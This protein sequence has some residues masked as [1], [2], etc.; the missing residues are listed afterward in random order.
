MT[1][2]LRRCLPEEGCGFLVGRGETA[3]RFV[4]APNSLGSRMAWAVRPGFLFDLSRELRLT[5]ESLLGI[6]HSHPAG[7]A[8]LSEDDIEAA[9]GH[10]DAFH[11]VVSFRSEAPEI[12]AWRILDGE[13][14]EAEL[15]AT[16]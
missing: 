15:H 8:R 3:S 7:D 2:H 16:I 6:C 12:R 4:P 1:G 14:R 11:V 13:A 10:P 9:A 5:G